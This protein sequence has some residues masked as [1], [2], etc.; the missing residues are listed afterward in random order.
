MVMVWRGFSPY[1]FMYFILVVLL[2]AFF[3]L[4]LTLAVINSS[5]A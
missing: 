5:F 1:M 3:L 4:N 2:G